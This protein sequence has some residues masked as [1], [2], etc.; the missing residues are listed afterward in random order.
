VTS[1]SQLTIPGLRPSPAF[2][3]RLSAT[4][5]NHVAKIVSELEVCGSSKIQ[6]KHE[7]EKKRIVFNR[8]LASVI[9]FVF[10]I[11]FALF[12]LQIADFAPT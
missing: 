1:D 6:S 5:R 9:V 7:D 12:H 3:A 4:G 2:L 11:I 8:K 10:T